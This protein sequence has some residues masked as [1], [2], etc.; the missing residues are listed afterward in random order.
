ME[1]GLDLLIALACIGMLSVAFYLAFTATNGKKARAGK[2]LTGAARSARALAVAR[3][4]AANEGVRLIAP[5]T[6]A[7]GGA[8]A[9][10]D[11]ILV[12]SF[13]VLCVK[14]LGLEGEIYGSAGDAKWL[15]VKGKEGAQ[16]RISFDNPLVQAGRDTRLVRDALFAAN[17]KSVPVE[18]VCVFTNKDAQLVLPRDTGHYTVKSFRDLLDKD[19]FHQDRKVDAAAAE[20]A[21]RA[22][23]APEAARKDA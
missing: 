2:E 14:C 12:G 15:Q 21:L 18:T 8:Y 13:G 22:N 20:A 19:R 10:I 7:R 23:L 6:L 1:N 9:D 4:F 17:L 16:Q 3:R 11:F 5:A